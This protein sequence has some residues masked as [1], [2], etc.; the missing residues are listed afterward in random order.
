MKRMNA[1]GFTLLE[2]MIVISIIGILAAVT[3]PK[4]SG[5]KADFR[6]R[7]ASRACVLDIRY[8]Q[9]LSM[10]TKEKHGVFFS[11]NGY[12]IKNIVTDETIKSI[13]FGNGV[14]YVSDSLSGD[15]VIFQ[16]DG[17]PYKSDGITEFST[18]SRIDFVMNSVNFHVY[19]KLTPRTGEVSASWN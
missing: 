7:T 6:L 10:D 3:W 8:A 14:Q 2:L 17:V 12:I 1:R 18:E 11:Q 9:Q 15:A 4:L 16:T 13:S 5:V 19:I